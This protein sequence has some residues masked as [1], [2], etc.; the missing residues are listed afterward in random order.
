MRY[1]TTST[2]DV[3]SLIDEE[4][5]G[6]WMLRDALGADHLGV[7]VLELEPGGTGKRHDH[8][9][10]DHEEV[11]LVVEGTLEVDLDGETVTL[12]PLEAV[13]VD[14]E[15]TRQLHNR[16]DDSVMVVIAGAP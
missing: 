13:R 8:A 14:A 15:T 1:Q 5:G 4:W 7:T 16:G 12:G 3:A 9:G 6:M 10:S 11:Y 2:D